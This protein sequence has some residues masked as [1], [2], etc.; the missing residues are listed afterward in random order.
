MILRPAGILLAAGASQRM[1]GEPK[2]LLP[3]REAGT[4]ILERLI[5]LYSRCCDPVVVVIGH[6]AERVKMGTRRANVQWIENPMPE[7]GQFSSMQCGL[8][9]V[10]A[11]CSVIFQPVDYAGV[12]ELTIAL[13][14][15][16]DAPL[17]IPRFAGERGHPVRLGPELI[18]EL[19]ALA[20]EAQARDVIRARYSQAVFLDVEDRWVTAD[21]DTPEDY[22]QWV[23]ATS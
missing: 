19:R 15:G 2:A 22:R 7:R 13:L 1:G 8:A 10:D 4:T 14:A 12:D 3:S 23:S 17:A 11:G 18:A 16:T 20:P 21:L 9:A 5:D 6:Q